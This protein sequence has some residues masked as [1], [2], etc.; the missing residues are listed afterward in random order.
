M[1]KGYAALNTEAS[2]S[3][4]HR[5]TVAF[6]SAGTDMRVRQPTEHYAVLHG[7][8][9]IIGSPIDTAFAGDHA[10]WCFGR[11]LQ[12]ATG[13]AACC[14]TNDSTYATITRMGTRALF[15]N[16]LGDGRAMDGGDTLFWFAG[17]ANEQRRLRAPRSWPVER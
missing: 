1:R 9:F 15:A 16:S 14:E 4:A 6:R 13:V 17:L 7:D 12:F 11:L 10:R 5:F 8:P 3:H 2:L